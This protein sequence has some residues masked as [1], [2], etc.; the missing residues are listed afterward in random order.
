M[1][2]RNSTWHF[3]YAS[4]M[5]VMTDRM[6]YAGSPSVT[7]IVEHEMEGCFIFTVFTDL[8]KIRLKFQSQSFDSL[9]KHIL[10]TWCF[11]FSGP[12][13]SSPPVTGWPVALAF[14]GI[15]QLHNNFASDR[16]LSNPWVGGDIG[17]NKM[18]AGAKFWTRISCC[19]SKVW[20]VWVLSST[21][22]YELSNM[23]CC[24]LTLYFQVGL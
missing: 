14:D 13:K 10:D 4:M 1:H 8:V 16:D 21:L 7:E 20:T 12:F 3:H 9:T 15:I 2:Q 24:F 6:Y 17:S 5:I 18:I 19:A 23:F 11:V 22:V